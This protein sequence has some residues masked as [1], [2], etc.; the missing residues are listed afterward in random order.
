MPKDDRKQINVRVDDPQLGRIE[1]L[2]RNRS[3]IPNVSELFRLLVDE[4]Y[5]REIGKGKRK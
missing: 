4:A 2:R 5:D 3:P 1:E